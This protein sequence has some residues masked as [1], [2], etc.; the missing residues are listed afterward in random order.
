MTNFGLPEKTIILINNLFASFDEIIEVKIFGS[1]AKG[2]FKNG[3][4]IDFAVTGNINDKFI[5]HIAAQ[6]D[7]LSTP[8]KFDIVNYNDINNSALKQNIDNCYLY[9]IC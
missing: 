7:E 2:N 6:L 1:R 4:D 9:H 8:Y 3:S 5:R